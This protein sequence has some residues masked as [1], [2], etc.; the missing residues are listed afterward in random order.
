MYYFLHFHSIPS[1][2][3]ENLRG[4]RHTGG[5]DGVIWIDVNVFLRRRG[6]R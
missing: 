2:F 3:K 4:S 1:N 6:R 5:L